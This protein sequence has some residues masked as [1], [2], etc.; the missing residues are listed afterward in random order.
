MT[1]LRL[2]RKDPQ[3]GEFVLMKKREVYCKKLVNEQ[4]TLLANEVKNLT[5]FAIEVTNTPPVSKLIK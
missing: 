2:V 1:I 5:G 3:T 4:I